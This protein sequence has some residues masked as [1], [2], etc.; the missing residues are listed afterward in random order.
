MGIGAKY[1]HGVRKPATY[2]GDVWLSRE[3]G[4]EVREMGG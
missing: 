2:E 1:N 4:D 3:M